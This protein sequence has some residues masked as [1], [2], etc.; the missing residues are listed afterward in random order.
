MKGKFKSFHEKIYQLLLASKAS[1]SEAYSKET[2]KSLFQRITKEHAEN[3]AQMNKA[4]SE[5]T[6][7]CKSTTEKV[8]KLISGT[9]TFMENYQTTYNNNTA[10]VNEAL[11]NLGAMFIT[12]KKNLEKIHTGLQQDHASFQT[13]LTLQ[14]TMLQDDLAMESKIMNGLAR[15]TKKVKVLAFKLQHFEKKVKDLLSER[16]V[17]R[18]CISNVTILLSDIIETRDSMISVIVHKHLAEKLR[19]I[20]TMSHHLQGVSP[21]SSDQKQG[22]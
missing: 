3:D 22:G 1:S 13:S 4:V 18:S 6:E 17:V 2:I 11:Q 15:N 9:T 16:V 21:Q 5:S 10:F 7:V 8:D 20:F 12:K 19:P 14:I